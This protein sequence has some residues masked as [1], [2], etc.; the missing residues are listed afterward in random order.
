IADLHDDPSVEEAAAYVN[1]LGYQEHTGPRIPRLYQRNGFPHC[2]FIST[3]GT[4]VVSP[5]CAYVWFYHEQGLWVGTT[6][7]HA[8]PRPVVVPWA[9]LDPGA[10]ELAYLAL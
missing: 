3:D 4:Y 9:E 10:I 8:V 7:D 5:Y 6:E 1:G 2:L